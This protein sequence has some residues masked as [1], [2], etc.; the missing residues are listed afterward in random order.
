MAN[1]QNYPRIGEPSKLAGYLDEKRLV[2]HTRIIE[3][4]KLKKIIEHSVEYANKKSSRAILEIP[5][6]ATDDQVRQVYLKEGKSLLDYFRK[7][8]GDPASTAYECA[9]RHYSD[10]AKEQFHNRTLQKDR[11]NSGW[12]YQRIAYQCAEASKRFKSVSDIGAIEADFNITVETVDCPGIPIVNIYISVKNRTNT[13]GGQDWPKAIYALEEVAQSDKNR[14]GPYLCIFG[15]AMGRGQRSIKRKRK[16][17]QLYSSNTEVW[18]SDFFWPFVANSSYEAMMMAVSDF[19]A[20]QGV[21]VENR[22]IGIPVPNDLIESFGEECRKLGLVNT[23]GKF[24][25]RRKLVTFFCT[26]P[27]KVKKPKAKKKSHE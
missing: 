14:S 4:Q 6:D 20:E 7:Y 25:D 26:K 10:I 27:A 9:G 11:M 8:C 2:P 12:R 23:D 17:K 16:T 1:V 13:L 21:T 18:L 22:T 24:N 3:E 19:F 15:I 5:E